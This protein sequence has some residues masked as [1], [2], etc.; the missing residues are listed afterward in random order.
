MRSRFVQVLVPTAVVLAVLVAVRHVYAQAKPP[1][2]VAELQESAKKAATEIYG[3]RFKQA[4]TS[5]EKTALATEMIEAAAKVQDGSPD[6]YVLL[7]IAADIAATAGDAPTALQAVEKMAE[8]FDVPGPKLTAETLLAAAG[9]ATTTSQ[10]KAVAE[11][12][13]KIA[14]SV[15]NAEEYT[16]ALSL[17]E[18]AKSSAQKARQYPLV[19]ELAAKSDDFQKRQRAFQEYKAAWALMQDDPAEPAANL[20]AGRYQCFVKGDW[21]WGVPM[22]ALGSDKAL[23]NAALMELRQAN[24]AEQQAAIGDAWWDAAETRQGEERNLLQ[25]RAGLWYRQAE[26]KLAG[27]LA[28]IKIK[29]RLAEVAKLGR[30]IPMATNEAPVPSEPT[31]SGKPVKPRTTDPRS[32]PFAEAVLLMTFEPD[33]ITSKDG[34]VQVA[35]LSGNGNDGT[36]ED[37]TPIPLGRAGGALQFGGTGSVLLPTLGNHLTSDLK[38]FSLALWVWQA[39]I[40]G[41][42]MIFDAGGWGSSGITLYRNNGGFRFMLPGGM[43]RG[44]CMFPRCQPR[45]WYHLV[46]VW[47]GAEMGLYVNG[48]LAARV[49]GE[50]PA[51]SAE[52]ASKYPARLGT[53]ASGRDKQ[54]Y[55]RGI[56]DEVAVFRRAL[57]EQEIQVLLQLGAQGQPLIKA[58]RTRSGR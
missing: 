44:D 50:G 49:P 31:A 14:D 33:T 47:T 58:A 51:L 27:G 42:A 37:A 1:V 29:Q 30:E 10:H 32:Q 2:P 57:S 3:G 11:A 41:N 15:A 43:A 53:L 22:L 36:V 9:N 16:L 4:K 17:C 46:C 55:F 6:Q 24:S 7:K 26:P 45:S 38:Q 34:K 23:K 25:L 19:K 18:L 28:G 40:D 39:D 21:A 48:Q 13:L 35:D 56:I 12:A 20:T 5:A 52:A 8:R 54:L